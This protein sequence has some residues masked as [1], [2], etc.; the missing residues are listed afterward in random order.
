MGEEL[1]EILGQNGKASSV[2]YKN[3]SEE[4]TCEFV[5]LTVDV[6][7]NIDFIRS[8]GISINIGIV[9]AE[10]LQTSANY[11]YALIRL[12]LLFLLWALPSR[13][14]IQILYPIS[15]FNSDMT[16]ELCTLPILSRDASF[17]L[18]KS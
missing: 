11:V 8:S 5:G 16:K 17:L 18:T 10:Y 9:A 2:I 14:I 15:D 4:I 3:S 6:S 13:L 1:Q 12:F 7:P